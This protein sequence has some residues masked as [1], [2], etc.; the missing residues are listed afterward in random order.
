VDLRATTVGQEM[1]IL[2]LTGKLGGRAQSAAKEKPNLHPATRARRETALVR[3]RIV[4]I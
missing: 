1:P 3:P 2:G 4:L